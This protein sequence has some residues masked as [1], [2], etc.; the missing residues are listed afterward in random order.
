MKTVHPIVLSILAAL[1]GCAKPPSSL[2]SDPTVVPPA[3]DPTKAPA[4][5]PGAYS[6]GEKNTYNHAAD[7]GELGARDPFSILAQRQDEGPPEVRTRLHSC[8]KVQY[9]T[10]GNILSDLGVNMGNTGQKPPSAADLYN[11]GGSALGV[12][13]YDARV[14]ETIV[15]SAAGAAKLFDIFVQAAPEIIA[16]IGSAPACQVNGQGVSMF[17]AQN[18]CNADAVTCLLGRPASAA[19]VDVCSALVQQASD[20]PTGQNIAVATILAATHSCE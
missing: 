12:A 16:N 1:A 14:G 18:R 9:E 15:W 20:I 6:G 8:Q 4:A 19:Q 5:L 17:D 3:D 13:D 11:A 10:L 2:M 7:L